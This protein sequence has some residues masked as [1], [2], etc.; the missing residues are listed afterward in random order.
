M[1]LAEHHERGGEGALAAAWYRRAAV[2]ALNGNDYVAVLARAERGL[3]CGP[4]VEVRPLLE[5][6]LAEAHRARGE[7][8]L[9]Y[10]RARAAL[11]G[12]EPGQAAW[13]AAAHE[14]GSS[15]GNMGDIAAVRVLAEALHPKNARGPLTQ[16]A[17]I[18][19]ANVAVEMLVSTPDA[20]MLDAIVAAVGPNDR[21][22]QAHVLHTLA[23]SAYVNG[24]F[25]EY[26][27]GMMKA[28]EA[29]KR[30]GDMRSHARAMVNF[31]AGWTL[32]GD[33]KRAEATCREALAIADPLGLGF[34]SALARN[35]LGLPLLRLGRI[36]EA[37]REL[38]ASAAAFRAQQHTRLLAG[39]Y[40]LMALALH[41]NGELDAAEV[42][43]N[44][45]VDLAT[46]PGTL[47]RPLAVLSMVRLA[48][49]DGPGALAAA[50]KAIAQRGADARGLND[51]VVRLAYGEALLATGPS[52]AAR[53]I[54]SLGRDGLLARAAKISDPARRQTF[55]TQ[56][57]EHARL[58][59]LASETDPAAGVK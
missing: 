31:G 56:I 54:L 18:A 15:A 38:E 39:T 46:L 44:V 10:A 29:F 53:G 51:A 17:L 50:E 59:R 19:G 2:D 34:V 36:D 7:N 12:L 47:S 42:Q 43:A 5:L 21:A 32:L 13:Y 23:V 25:V 8:A 24:D 14:A 27:D 22:A 4:S 55:L 20:E 16:E 49:G 48:R 37:L 30:I 57:P 3:A 6:A 40:E 1:A 11:E 58:L 26:L 52:E 45:A 33:W 28:M 41:A 35:N 9:A